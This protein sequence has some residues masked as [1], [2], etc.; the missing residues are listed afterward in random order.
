MPKV[1]IASIDADKL[2]DQKFIPKM[3]AIFDLFRSVITLQEY[4]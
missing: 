1:R 2:K 3:L 4:S